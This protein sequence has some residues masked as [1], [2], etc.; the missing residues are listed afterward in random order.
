MPFSVYFELFFYFFAEEGSRGGTGD[1]NLYEFADMVVALID[2]YRLVLLC[3]T[4]HL[5]TATLAEVLDEDGEF[6]ALIFLVLLC[7][8]LCLELDQFVEAGYLGFLRNIVR[9]VL[10]GVGARA[11]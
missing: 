11:L 7:A 1:A 5:L 3:A 4:H 8:H 10:G 2:D 9:Q 6:L